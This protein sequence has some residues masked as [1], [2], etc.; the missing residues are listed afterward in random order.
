MM[1]AQASS[2]AANGWPTSGTTFTT[3]EDTRQGSATRPHP[4]IVTAIASM[5]SR[6][7]GAREDI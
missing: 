1:S 6:R 5:T 2:G 3:D 4:D 7:S